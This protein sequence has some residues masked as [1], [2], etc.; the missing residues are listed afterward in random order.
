MNKDFYISEG[1]RSRSWIA[2]ARAR[3]LFF[4][5]VAWSVR[6]SVCLLV[7]NVSRAKTAE[8]IEMPSAGMWTHMEPNETAL[9]GDR[10]RHG[11]GQHFWR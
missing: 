4:S 1:G 8:P 7:T 3:G 10:I 11:K 6:L 5:V 9:G 2:S